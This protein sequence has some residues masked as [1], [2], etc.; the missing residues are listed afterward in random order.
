MPTRLDD[1]CPCGSRQRYR[2][3]CRPLELRLRRIAAA[4]PEWQ[5]DL[6]PLGVELSDLPE[7]RPGAILVTAGDQPL[8]VEVV[9][10]CPTDAAEAGEELAD[11]LDRLGRRLR[12][13]PARLFVRRRAIAR[14]LARGL[15][16]RERLASIE[17]RPLAELDVLAA[18]LRASLGRGSAPSEERAAEVEPEPEEEEEPLA[19]PRAAWPETWAGWGLAAER[20]AE[21]HRQAAAFYRAAP[22]SCL[23]EDQILEAEGPSGQT[24]AVGLLGKGVRGI[25]LFGAPRGAT[26]G[27][28]VLYLLFS[29]GSALPRPM[30]KEV[31]AAGWEVVDPTAYP[32]L[33][34]SHPPPEGFTTA[35]A[36]DLTALLVAIP[37]LVARHGARL[38]REE[39]I[40]SFTHKPSGARLRYRPRAPR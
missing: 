11:A 23:R 21:L 39:P 7:A 10:Y 22:W 13:F 6:V 36:G 28:V 35:D 33:W 40:R 29:D 38:E 31:S 16:D 14:W 19:A 37:A 1:P 24:W 34:T 12:T 18:D 30:R 32:M 8:E 26:V 25:G 4:T 15:A 27:G 5:V 2:S 20:C 9:H 17:V 3:C